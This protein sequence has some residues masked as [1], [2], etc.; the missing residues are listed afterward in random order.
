M[1]IQIPNRFQ[2]QPDWRTQLQQDYEAAPGG[3]P[4]KQDRNFKVNSKLPKLKMDFRLEFY[5]EDSK[6]WFA[7]LEC[8]MLTLG[9]KSQLSKKRH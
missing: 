3:G 8:N 1:T 4:R 7:T 9:I 2:V 6:L 5:Q